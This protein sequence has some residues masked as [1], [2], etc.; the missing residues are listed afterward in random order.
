MSDASNLP[1]AQPIIMTKADLTAFAHT[2][3]AQTFAERPVEM[4]ND[5]QLVVCSGPLLI[6]I[7]AHEV[8]VDGFTARLKSR[9]FAV[10]AALGRNLGHV[11]SRATLLRLAWPNPEALYDERTVDVHIVR[12][13]KKLGAAGKLIETVHSVGYKLRQEPARIER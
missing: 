7:P 10:L 12:L 3:I 4:A 6:D 8:S 11:L 13:R 5:S 9:E 2:I 1:D